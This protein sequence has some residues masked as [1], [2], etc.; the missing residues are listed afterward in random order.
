MGCITGG[1]CIDACDAVMKKIHR[2]T[3]LI[4]FGNDDNRARRMRGEVE[5]HHPIRPRTVMYA[6]LIALTAGIMLYVLATRANSHLSV[7][8]VRAP[9]YTQTAEGGIRN[10][11]TLRFSNKLADPQD[12]ALEVAGLPGAILTSVA[13]KTLPDGRLGVRLDADST[14]EIPVYVTSPSN[15]NLSAASTPITFTAVDV[16]TDERN[17][18]GDHFFGPGAAQ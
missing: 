15:L 16:Q 12:F 5:V 4:A 10:G 7:L 1:L 14:L 9:L 2:P 8:H 11:F 6:A 18:V 13:A 17:V 3:R